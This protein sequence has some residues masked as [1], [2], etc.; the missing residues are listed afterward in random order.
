MSYR[1]SRGFR[2]TLRV[3]GWTVGL[4]IMIPLY[5]AGTAFQSI[6]VAQQCV[7]EA[8]VKGGQQSSLFHAQRFS[9]CMFLKS[10]Y[11][12]SRRL[13]PAL[14]DVMALQAAPCAHVGI[15]KSARRRSVYRVTMQDDNTFSSQPVADFGPSRNSG[16]V[17]G[18]WG[19]NDGKM[20]WIYDNGVFWPP[21]INRIEAE[22][23]D[24]FTL[25]EVNGERTEF[26][27]ERQLESARCPSA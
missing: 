17:T 12:E 13:E 18:Y 11:L 1:G 15:W 26:T 10:S 9:L 2:W 24:K 20:V 3:I 6:E 23:P 8:S 16:G 5:R 21:D 7:G 14:R 22:S 25:I 4:A 27:R 19:E